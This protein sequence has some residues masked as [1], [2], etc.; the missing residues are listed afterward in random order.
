MRVD[1]PDTVTSAPV[2][3]P[4]KFTVQDSLESVDAKEWNRLGGDHEPFLSH[5]FLVA[6]ERNG[7]VGE[8]YGW[9]P[10]HVLVHDTM[11]RLL[12]ALPLYAKTN[13]YGEFVFDWS[14]ADAYQRMG[15]RYYPKLVASTP[16]TPVTGARLL[17]A[18]QAGDAHIKSGLIEYAIE[19]ARDN[20]YSGLH[21]LFTNPEDTH[22]LQ[23]R[24][25]ILRLGCQYHW[26]NHGYADFE[27]FLENLTSRKRKK[28]RRERRRVAEQGISLKVMHGNEIDAPLW[29]T[30]HQLYTSIFERKFGIATL[31]Q[32]FFQEIGRSMGARLVVIVAYH[33]DRT[34]ACALNLRSQDTL[35]GR[36]WGCA[37]DFHSLHFEACYYQGIEYCIRHGLVRFEPG[38]QGEHK[39]SRGFLPTQTWSAH[40]IANDDFRRTIANFC[41]WERGMIQTQCRELAA[42]SP[43]RSDREPRCDDN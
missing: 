37:R 7:C 11:G 38:A 34:V 23:A 20:G 19:F 9:H 32:D 36:I 41:Q 14:W 1:S 43:Y 15:L 42:L 8:T 26:H 13:S 35:Y 5:Q 29:H 17:V 24:G 27:H 22:R 39:I 21:W 31:T 3:P 33:Q 2:S 18:P 25:M 30:I 6:L 4:F 40:W 28:V 10:K 16:Y 12:G